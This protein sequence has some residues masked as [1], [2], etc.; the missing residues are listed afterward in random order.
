MELHSFDREE[1]IVRAV[2]NLNANIFRID[3]SDQNENVLFFKVS[4]KYFPPQSHNPFKLGQKNILFS[5]VTIVR[6]AN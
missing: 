1:M 4:L 2:P 5:V 6:H 3:F